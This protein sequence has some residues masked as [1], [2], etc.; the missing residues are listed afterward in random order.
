MVGL[1]EGGNELPGSLKAI[2]KYGRIVRPVP[3]GRFVPSGLPNSNRLMSVSM[4]GSRAEFHVWTCRPVP[5]GVQKNSEP[6]ERPDVG[7]LPE[8]EA[9]TPEP[10][11]QSEDRGK[12]RT[13]ISPEKG[14]TASQKGKGR[15][16]CS[17]MRHF[18]L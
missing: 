11:P 8:H 12:K 14:S 15:A 17:K 16:K 3:T 6:E 2:S 18:Q 5:R 9:Q 4:K 1:C 10:S 13:F 7:A